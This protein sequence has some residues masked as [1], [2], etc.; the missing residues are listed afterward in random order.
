MSQLSERLEEL[1]A[2]KEE[3]EQLQAD[4]QQLMEANKRYHLH[5]D[6]LKEK[7]ESLLVSQR[8]DPSACLQ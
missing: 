7:I 1:Q 4:N 3:S 5:T 8:S 2:I 6:E